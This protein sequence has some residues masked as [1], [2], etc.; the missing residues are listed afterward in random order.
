MDPTEILNGRGTELHGGR[1][2]PI[3]MKAVYLADCDSG[4][5]AEV[6]ARKKRLGRASQI[7][8]DKYPRVIYA[9]D[10]AWNA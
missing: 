3:G 4:A 9:V 5:S 6:L 1:F 7:S 10:V 8:L 2:A